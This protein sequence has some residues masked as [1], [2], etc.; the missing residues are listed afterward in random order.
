[1]GPASRVFV[2]FVVCLLFSFVTAKSGMVGWGPAAWAQDDEEQSESDEL[3]S[4]TPAKKT[5]V[6]KA[7]RAVKKTVKKPLKKATKK[8]KSKPA[9]DELDEDAAETAPEETA[10]SVVNEEQ[11]PIKI[12]SNARELAVR[13]IGVSK[14]SVLASA[15]K[16]VPKDLETRLHERMVQE[17]AAK[18]YFEPQAIDGTFDLKTRGS[19]IA[20]VTKRTSTDGI[21]V[22]QIGL[23][24]IDG[25]LAAASGRRIRTFQFKYKVGELEEKNAVSVIADRLIEGVVGAIPYRGYVT[26]SEKVGTATVNLGTNHGIKE[27]DIFKLFEFRRPSFHSTHKLLMEV[28]VKKV[29]GPTESQIQILPSASKDTRIEPFSKVSFSLAKTTTVAATDHSVVSGRW[30]FE[31]GGELNSF[32]AEA[33]AP[34]YETRVFK[35]NGAPFGYAAMGNDVL[36]FRGAFGSGRSDRET[37]TF[38]DGQAT[39][40]AYQ[41]GGAQSAWTVGAGARVFMITVSPNVGVV[42]SLESTMLVSPMA[43]LKYQYVPRGRIRLVGTVE[44]FWPIYTTGAQVSAL[45]FA[46]GA[47]AGGGLQLAITNKFGIEVFGKLRYLRRPIDGQSGVQERQSVLGAGLLFSF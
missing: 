32:S 8:K 17:L 15:R 20:A 18:T 47:G 28:V 3:N 19:D 14:M 38:I 42:S 23:E 1:M 43:E 30:W 5:K 40:G 11:D 35:V 25:Y 6:K 16:F 13:A 31:F 33:A 12:G 22:F 9:A 41:F 7:K 10:E 4:D 45:I 39:Y 24:Q 2:I 29:V 34:K 46:F 21:L 44:V 37:L 36:T 27:G 26:S